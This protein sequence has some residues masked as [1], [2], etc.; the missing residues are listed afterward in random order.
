[1]SSETEGSW[2]QNCVPQAYKSD[3]LIHE[4]GSGSRH[5]WNSSRIVVDYESYAP[6]ANSVQV[7]I[8]SISLRR[9]FALSHGVTGN[10]GAQRCAT[11]S[12]SFPY[13]PIP[14]SYYQFFLPGDDQPHGLMLPGI[15]EKMPWTTDFDVKHENPRKV[16]VLDSSCGKST[17]NAVNTALQAL[18]SMC[19]SRDMFHVLCAQHSEPS[20]IPGSNHDVPIQIERFASG[21]FGITS[22]GAHLVAYTREDG[23]ISKL[24]IARRSK[25]LYSYPNMLDTT[26]AGGIKSGVSP[27]ETIVEE[28]H[29]EASLPGDFIRSQVRSRGVIS[30]MSVTKEDFAGEQG[31]VVPD[32]IYVYDVEIPSQ[33]KPDPNDDEVS[34]F[35]LKTISEV[36]MALLRQE[37]KPDSAA[38]LIDFMI[39][40]SIITPDNE[41]DF[42]EISMRLHRRL[43]FR[44]G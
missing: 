21:L 30:H 37:F 7:T 9:R 33:L 35:Y 34:A 29:E 41:Q 28:A 16:T 23:Q 3:H 43:P 40:H 8:S 24:W 12:S 2:A 15:V 31:L 26:V 13:G 10:K 14:P 18:I 27:L 42:V 36:Q 19:I 25:H 5:R 11:L 39:R 4:A 38:V 17:A 22:R 32:Y 44:T 1:M 20:A 6:R